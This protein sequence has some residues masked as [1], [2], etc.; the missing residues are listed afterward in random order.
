MPK[1]IVGPG[2]IAELDRFR[3]VRVQ[4]APLALLALQADQHAAHSLRQRIDGG[5]MG[6]PVTA[7]FIAADQGHAEVP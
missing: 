1:E 6:V 2:T 4:H 3:P 7:D 5:G